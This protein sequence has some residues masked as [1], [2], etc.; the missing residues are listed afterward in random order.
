MP[1]YE[2]VCETCD[3][4]F[5]INASIFEDLTNAECPECHGKDTHKKYSFFMA[6][7]GGSTGSSSSCGG[8]GGRFT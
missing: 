7:F 2:F 1:I 6:S 8:G 4:T 5:E 3:H